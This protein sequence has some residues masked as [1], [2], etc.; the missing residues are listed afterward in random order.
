MTLATLFQSDSEAG[1][2]AEASTTAAP[3]SPIQ[4]SILMR[5]SAHLLAVGIDQGG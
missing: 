1:R 4:I 2:D 5:V 3:A